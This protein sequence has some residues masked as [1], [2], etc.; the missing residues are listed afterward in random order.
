MCFLNRVDWKCRR[1]NSSNQS[2][3]SLTLSWQW[4]VGGLLVLVLMVDPV[5]AQK[6]TKPL[7][8]VAGLATPFVFETQGKLAGFSIDLWRS[9]NDEMGVK[10]ELFAN[11]TTQ[12]LLSAVK[13]G[14]ADVGIGNISITAER[15]KNFDFS[16]PIFESGLQILVPEQSGGMRSVPSLLAVIFSPE[17]VQLIGII[18]VIILVP[19]HIVWFV[20]RRRSGGIISTASYFPGIFKACWW[21]A[22]T[23]ATQ[24][25]EMPK[26]P[27]GRI[28]AVIWMFTSVVFIAYFTATV[29]TSLTVQE[30]Q[31]NIKGPDDLLGKR[32]ATSSGST[33]AVYL[34]QKN[35]QVLESNRLAEA[36]EA[37][38]QGKA[39]AVVF[40]APV[41]L[42][43]ASHEGKGKVKVIGSVFRQENYGIVFPPNS[44][45]R[46][47]INEA[48]L[49]LQENGTYQ[50][51]YQKWFTSK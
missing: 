21:A 46:K 48:L 35:I 14:K 7:R 17:F 34:H 31:G 5:S 24:A 51:L 50:E 8:V 33:S 49:T 13:S 23:L 37:L 20:E 16:Q 9:I 30:L 43:Y 39:D 6:P 47:P 2:S 3:K 19:A 28:V 29:T 26:S 27:L 4:L 15:E 10:S 11:S 41:L 32:V 1:D 40:D 12:A 45:Y 44:P 25:E 36:Y 22:S 42:Y 38:L 18:L